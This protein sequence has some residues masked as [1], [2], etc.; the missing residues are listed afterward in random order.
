VAKPAAAFRWRQPC[1]ERNRYRLGSDIVADDAGRL[2]YSASAIAPV[3][4]GVSRAPDTLV[5][6]LSEAYRPEPPGWRSPL[7]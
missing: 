5:R 2:L 7:V 3:R 6:A 4:A 1:R